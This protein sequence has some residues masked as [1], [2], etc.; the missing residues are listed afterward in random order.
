MRR[1]L[2][3][4]IFGLV[5]CAILISLGI[6]QLRRL[7][8]KQ[9]MLAQ[10]EARIHD[11]PIPLPAT[12]DPEAKYTPVTVTGTTGDEL[13]VLSGQKGIG[14]GYEVITAFATDDGRRVLLDRGFFPEPQG[15]YGWEVRHPPTRLSVMGHLH[16]PQET[17]SATPPPDPKRNLWFAR[18]VPAMAAA[19]QTEPILVVAARIEGD[20]QSVTPQPIS[21]TGI[22]ND[23]LG[24]A[25]Q[26]F[27][28][29]AV[30]AGMTA[31]FIW[32]ITR[33]TNQGA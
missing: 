24:Y 22:P 11:A 13:L 27:A 5:G 28:L 31:F 32:R 26:W 3:P 16:W 29:A 4:L 9:A 12:A 1:I 33:R 6:W 2:V 18:D 17:G 14:A 15:Q 21:I 25:I 8:W 7:E 10:I 19:L 20:T 23:H 30:W